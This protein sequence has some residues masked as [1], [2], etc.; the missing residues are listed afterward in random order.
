MVDIQTNNKDENYEYRASSDIHPHP[1]KYMCEHHWNQC[2]L[3]M[4]VT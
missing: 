3:Q 2:G 4:F 1:L